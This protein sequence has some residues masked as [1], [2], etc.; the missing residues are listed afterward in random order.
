[1]AISLALFLGWVGTIFVLSAI[2]NPALDLEIPH[3]TVNSF[4]KHFVEYGILGVLT[5]NL[6]RQI[7]RNQKKAV[8]FSVLFPFLYGVTD[9]IHQ[10]FVPTRIC[11]Y[12][13]VIVDTLGGLAGVL[14]LVLILYLK[15]GKRWKTF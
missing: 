11:D 1:M 13:D 6:F 10:Y 14:L 7:F 9:E 3:V 4:F 15:K 5:F 12:P 8:V 2:Q